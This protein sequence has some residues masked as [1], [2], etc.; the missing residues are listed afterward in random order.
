MNRICKYHKLCW[1]LK[2]IH[3][4]GDDVTEKSVASANQHNLIF[5]IF[6]LKFSSLSMV[7]WQ[8]NFETQQSK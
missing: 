3:L 5:K 4:D 7:M 8:S 6:D 1:V 2:A